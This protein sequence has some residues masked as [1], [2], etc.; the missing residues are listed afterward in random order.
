M[1]KKQKIWK[2]NVIN[3]FDSETRKWL[4]RM[5]LNDWIVT[6]RFSLQPYEEWNKVAR[7]DTTL[8]TCEPD[9]VYNKAVITYFPSI[10]EE[11]N[12]P[13]H[14]EYTINCIKHEVCHLITAKIWEIAKDR[15]ATEQEINNEIENLTQKLSILIEDELQPT[16]TKRANKRNKV[17]AKPKK[18][19]KHS[20]T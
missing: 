3:W 6:V 5:N 14:P 2:K 1:K 7:D 15:H 8:A 19:T 10:L 20:S 18:Q 4:K 16:T 17:L 11:Y 13:R 9:S 12:W